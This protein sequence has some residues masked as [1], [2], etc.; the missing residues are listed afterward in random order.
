MPYVAV[1]GTENGVRQTGISYPQSVNAAR[2]KAFAPDS[3]EG[4]IIE[5]AGYSIDF[6]PDDYYLKEIKAR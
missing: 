3:R 4:N 5:F 6:N 2:S 1:A